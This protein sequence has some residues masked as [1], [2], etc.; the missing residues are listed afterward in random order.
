MNKIFYNTF[1]KLFSG[2]FVWTAMSISPIAISRDKLISIL[3]N[4]LSG[5]FIISNII[6]EKFFVFCMFTWDYIYINLVANAISSLEK[7]L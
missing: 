6:F 4:I 2:Y 7:I 5:S 1:E 3:N